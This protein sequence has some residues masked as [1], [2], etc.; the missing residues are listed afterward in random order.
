MANSSLVLPGFPILLKKWWYKQVNR[1]TTLIW[2]LTLSDTWAISWGG[3]SS[4][5]LSR[6]VCIFSYNL[7]ANRHMKRCSL[8]LV[9]RKMQIKTIMRSLVRTTIIK[10]SKIINAGEDVE[11]RKPSYLAGRNVNRHSHNREQCGS[12]LKDL[13]IYHI[14]HDRIPYG[15]LFLMGHWGLLRMAG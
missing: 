10:K 11:K 14:S 2:L 8:S 6:R 1:H 15:A 7:W 4:A 9:I 5:P 13:K 3:S 12:S